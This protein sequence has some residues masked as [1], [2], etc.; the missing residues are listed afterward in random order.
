MDN[1]IYYWLAGLAG[2]FVVSIALSEFGIYT[3]KKRL[4]R[5]EEEVKQRNTEITSLG[6]ANVAYETRLKEFQADIERLKQEL[7]M[8]KLNEAAASTPYGQAIK[9]A[10][11]GVGVDELMDSCGLS[12]PE[13]ELI[14]TLHG[15]PNMR[16]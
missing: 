4:A 13:A 6:E 8:Q 14:L 15:S 10:Q 2:V 9:L 12:Q 5:L 3:L 7:E 1:T 16:S 11:R